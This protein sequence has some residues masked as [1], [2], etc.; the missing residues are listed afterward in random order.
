M[1]M[2][3]VEYL[4]PD[5]TSPFAKW[6]D[7]LDSQAAAKV[8]TAIVRMEHDNLSSLKGIGEGVAEYRIHSGAGIRVYIGQ[9][10]DTLIIL[11]AGGTK[12]RQQK[13]IETAKARWKDYKRRRK[14]EN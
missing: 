6:F 10:G 11:L 12:R 8:A 13:D 2:K 7:G 5:G 4:A 3:L 9:D 14:E 1:G